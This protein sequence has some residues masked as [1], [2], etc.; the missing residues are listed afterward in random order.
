MG[1]FDFFDPKKKDIAVETE[2]DLPSFTVDVNGFIMFKD[3]DLGGCGIFEVEPCV[4]GMGFTHTDS[5]QNGMD[6][7]SVSY[8]PQNGD[9]WKFRDRR[10]DVV[11]Q[12]VA[13]LNGLF[14]H[15]ES[16]TQ[17]QVQILLKKTRPY[18]W[19]TRYNYA[20]NEN[21]AVI[22]EFY[23]SRGYNSGNSRKARL[24]RA[25]ANDYLGFLKA[26][27]DESS[28]P[29]LT[30]DL[31]KL[32]SYA[33]KMY[34]VVSHTPSSEG[35]WI[36]GR[37]TDY[38]LKDESTPDALFK[39]SE[40]VDKIAGMLTK[41]SVQSMY[42]NG[43]NTA[44]DLFPFESD[45]TAQIIETRMRRIEQ[46]LAN[47]YEKI[48]PNDRAFFIRRLEPKE[49]AGLVKFFPNVLTPYFAK[50]MDVLHENINDIYY[51]FDTENASLTGDSG[52]MSRVAKDIIYGNVDLSLSDEEENEFLDKYRSMTWE[53]AEGT[54]DD[55]YA[56]EK[57]KLSAFND[58]AQSIADREYYGDDEDEPDELDDMWRDMGGFTINTTSDEDEETLRR[59]YLKRQG[60]KSLTVA[61][62]LE[63]KRLREERLQSHDAS[64]E[65]N[66]ERIDALASDG[67]NRASRR[68]RLN[69]DNPGAVARKRVIKNG[70]DGTGGTRRSGTKN[71]RQI[72]PRKK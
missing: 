41:R 67:E 62:T 42:D 1:L 45:I 16:E 59:E 3:P 58:A 22:G 10:H 48:P 72:D 55:V 63:N 34:I 43:N 49:A 70:G 6:T 2:N 8:D 33:V 5:L 20:F 14:P 27:S 13:F 32:D 54:I 56:S 52:Y 29:S 4:S 60:R 35:W 39:G 30:M 7:E 53:E 19:V 26:Q 25:R 47:I 37:D 57:D 28:R 69:R 21:D 24:M 31:N 65:Y 23:A 15:D 18:E 61:N 51:G 12:W 71:I 44:N 46:N 66:Q 9:G 36:D 17:T 68:R 38:Y 40:F 50:A 64:G 11:P